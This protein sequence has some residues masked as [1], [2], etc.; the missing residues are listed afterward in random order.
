MPHTLRVE[1]HT[2]VLAEDVAVDARRYGDLLAPLLGITKIEAKMLVRRG[3]GILLEDLDGP[4]AERVM[5]ELESDGVRA[6]SVKNESLPPMPQPRRVNWGQRSPGA[7]R[8]KW[9]GDE[10]LLDLGWN[11]VGVASVGLVATAEWK[12]A[13]AGIRFDAVP[14][15]HRF[16]GDDG[17]RE[18][19]R[20]NL[21]LRLTAPSGES[22]PAPRTKKQTDTVFERLATQDKVKVFVDVVDVDRALWLRF[23]MEE[24][25]YSCEEGGVRFGDAWGMNYLVADLVDRTPKAATEATLK[26]LG[27]ADIKEVVFLRLEEFNRYTAWNAIRR[28]LACADSSS[29]SPAPPAPSTDGASSSASPA[30]APPSTSP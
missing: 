27:G 29:P 19:I 3:R 2:I 13:Y 7:L 26:L 21:I 8:F 22:A 5:R 17:A 24:L 14:G 25:G 10:L 11:Q 9:A 20:E 30:P 23:P 16:G 12:D 28:S 18:L 15:L 6:W 4:A 1:L